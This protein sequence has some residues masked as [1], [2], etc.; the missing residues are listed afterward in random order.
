MCAWNI[1]GGVS[2]HIL[3]GWNV[4]A[5]VQ[6]NMTQMAAVPWISTYPS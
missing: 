5:G 3:S 1:T 6:Q 2:T 4:G